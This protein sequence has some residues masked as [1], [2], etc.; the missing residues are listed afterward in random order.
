MEK[1]K[2]HVLLV[3][4]EEDVFLWI[5]DLLEDAEIFCWVKTI[6]CDSEIATF[7]LDYARTYD[8]AIDKIKQARH[9]IYLIDYHLGEKDGLDLLREAVAN[10]C[11]A[12]IIMLTGMGDISIDHSAMKAG[13]ADYLNKY[14][15]S[16]EILERSMRYALERKVH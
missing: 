10:G 5:K 7:E 13:A 2:I 9:H 6:L 11:E 16:A 1:N 3:D 12:P 8:E 15:L 14:Q 4:D